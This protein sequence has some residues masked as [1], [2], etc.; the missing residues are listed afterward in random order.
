MPRPNYRPR[1]LR[2]STCGGAD[3][4]GATLVF[5]NLRGADLSS[6]RLAGADL[7]RA[8]L[9]GTKL[10]E[11]HARD[12]DLGGA[13][14]YNASMRMATLERARLRKTGLGTADLTETNLS[15]A[16]LAEA[17][18]HGA[19]LA[20]AVL[21]DACLRGADLRAADM[22][23]ANLS[24]ADLRHTNFQ[25]A[26][27]NH[28][29]LM[30]AFLGDTILTGADLRDATLGNTHLIHQNLAEFCRQR[31]HF[32]GPSHVDF[33]SLQ[34]SVRE[35]RLRKFLKATGMPDVFVEYMIDCARSLQPD[36]VFSLLQSTFI[37]YGGPDEPFARKLN[38]AL[39]Q[40]GVTTFFFKDDA[41]PGEKLH[42]VMRRG[43]NEHDRVILVCSK[44][45]L[46]RSGVLNELE[47]T[48]QRESRDGG[49]AYLIPVRID[50]YVIDGWKPSRS[51][52]AQA[53][54]DR[55]IADFSNHDDDRSFREELSKLVAVLRR[56]PVNPVVHI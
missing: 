56:K 18:L 44:S 15:N 50:G 43:V 27:L 36:Q 28:T 40:E 20:K 46:Q 51:G 33:V 52:L 13:R 6:A 9:I 41:P 1:D 53:V 3:L 19:R 55:V 2:E 47:E 29:T 32:F 17:N 26:K 5:A 25:S 35:P 42:R 16:D 54:R 37:S 8:T 10:D 38:D 30:G 48:L 24:G 11:I 12:A 7:S 31:V 39:E 49:N 22:S 21:Y 23:G 14:A 45:S 4:S 34:L